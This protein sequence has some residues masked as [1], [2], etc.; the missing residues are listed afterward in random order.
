MTRKGS[1]TSSRAAVHAAL[2]REILTLR[3]APGAALSENELAAGLGVSRTPVRESLILLA[4]EGLV[5]VFPQIGSFVSPIDPQRVT[6]AQFLRESVELAAL[7]DVP[8]P[9]DG[10][11]VARLQDNL[12]AQSAEDITMDRFFELDEQFHRTLLDLSGHG[13]VWQP[14]AAAKA[15]LDRARRLGAVRRHPIAD[16][17]AEHRAV[18]EAVTAGDRTGARRILREHLRRVLD[19]VEHVRAQSPEL[20]G[21][22]RRTPVRRSVPV[23]PQA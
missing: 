5:Q 4:D 9:P 2:R 22:Q 11:L 1:P 3:L 12:G 15:H 8:D 13:G 10:A 16:M 7:A 19:D 23:W 14:V 20:F 18:L 21:D 6:D 17:A